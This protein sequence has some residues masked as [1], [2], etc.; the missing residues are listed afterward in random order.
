R[1]REVDLAVQRH[2]VRHGFYPSVGHRDEA[3]PVLKR[4]GGPQASARMSM[5]RAASC[6]VAAAFWPSVTP[7]GHFNSAPFTM[8]PN[9]MTLS[10]AVAAAGAVA[11]IAAM[12]T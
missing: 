7:S 10:E 1:E 11:S 2:D 4:G 3:A 6:A 12:P 5:K 8:A 9:E